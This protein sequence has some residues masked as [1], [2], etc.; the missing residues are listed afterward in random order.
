MKKYLLTSKIIFIVI[1][2]V[3]IIF[4]S[5]ISIPIN[6]SPSFAAEVW[7]GVSGTIS[8][9]T[10]TFSGGDG[11]ASTPYLISNPTDLAQFASNVNANLAAYN[12]AYYLVT[13]D[14]ELND[15]TF[16]FDQDTGLV[17]VTDGTNTAYLGTGRKGDNSGSNNTF[18]NSPSAPG[19]F[20]IDMNRTEGV[21]NGAINIWTPTGNS[22]I[23]FYGNFDGGGYSIKGLY[24][25]NDQTY[26]GFFGRIDSSANLAY[27]AVTSSYICAYY[28]IGGIVASNN[29]GR[30]DNCYFNGTICHYNPSVWQSGNDVGGIL[31][32]GG[33]IITNC[34]FSGNIIG[35]GAVGGI[36]GC[37]TSGSLINCYNEGNITGERN[38]GGII[39]RTT[40]TIYVYNNYSVGRMITQATNGIG[41]LIGHSGDYTYFSN[42]Y[43]L[44][45]SG[46]ANNSIEFNNEGEF[47]NPITVGDYTGN[48]LLR[49]LNAWVDMQ[50]IPSDYQSWV[51]YVYPQFLSNYVPT[52][53]G[54]LGTEEEPYLIAYEDQLIFL[55]NIINNGVDAAVTKGGS[56]V[57][58][59]VLQTA[60]YRL[61]KNIILNDEI[62]ILDADSGL[63][64]MTDG[65]NTAYLGT[66]KIGNNSGSNTTFDTTA[67]QKG[68]I[69]TDMVGTTGDY[70]GEINQW[71]QIGTQD[72]AFQGHFDGG[73]YTVS[74]LYINTSSGS[75]HGL[76]GLS[77]GEIANLGVENSYVKGNEYGGAVLAY[78][79]SGTVNNC[80]NTGAVILSN[81][82]ACYAG[83]IVG[84][85]DNSAEVKNC[86]NTGLVL[87]SLYIGGVVGA[88]KEGSN[89]YNSYNNGEVKGHSY[90][91]GVVG[92]NSLNSS[93]ENSYNTGAVA[94]SHNWVGGIL[95]TNSQSSSIS[96]CYNTGSVIGNVCVGGVVG[97][98]ADINSTVNDC[99]YLSGTAKNGNN[100]TQFGIG[101]INVTSFTTDILGSTT[102]F[103][104]SGE[105]ATPQTVGEYNGNNLLLALK[106][107]VEDNYPSDYTYWKFS[108]GQ[109][110]G[111]PVLDNQVD[112]TLTLLYNDNILLADANVDL[113]LGEVGYKAIF[114]GGVYNAT[115]G[116]GVYD[117][118]VN[119]VDTGID[120]MVTGENTI[121]LYALSY[122]IGEATGT[123]PET[124]Y[125]GQGIEVNVSTDTNYEL[126]GYSFNGFGLAQ[127]ATSAVTEV[128]FSDEGITLYALF[129]IV[130][131]IIDISD[132]ALPYTYGA[133]ISATASHVL[134]EESGAEFSYEWKV[135]ETV[136]GTSID[137]TPSANASP[138]EITCSVTFSLGGKNSTS[139]VSKSYTIN[140][141]QLIDTT[142]GIDIAY[143]RQNHF[144]SV[145]AEGFVGVDTMGL[146]SITYC[147][148]EN[149][150]YTA[151][152]ILF[153]D[154]VSNKTVYYRAVFANYEDI[155]G[156]AAV[157][158]AKLNVRVFAD[159]KEIIFGESDVALTYQAEGLL[160]GDTLSGELTR[161]EGANAGRYL[162]NQG[163]LNSNNY[164]IEYHGAIYSIKAVSIETTE[165]TDNN[166]AIAIISNENGIDPSAR[167]VI[168]IIKQEDLDTKIK[169]PKNRR[170]VIAY[171]VELYINDEAVPLDGA[172]TI[173]FALPNGFEDVE[174]CE[175]LFL[176]NGELITKEVSVVNGY[177][178]LELLTQGEFAIITDLETS[179]VPVIIVLSV[180]GFEI[181]TIIILLILR[182]KKKKETGVIAL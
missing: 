42:N 127:N 77:S 126:N 117:L 167:L 7:D 142:N 143:D 51:G 65:V 133:T 21:Y 70:L 166:E 58:Y 93:I 20:Y 46:P 26:M 56:S 171:Q 2:F 129:N 43:H 135:G 107:W 121:I 15:E 92:S 69:Y 17:I 55:S 155:V 163:S 73:N 31:G 161:E 164:N 178:T 37:K 63:I 100:I 151:D 8:D 116:F 144:I 76:F 12:A 54:G 123:A 104:G 79:A 109:N 61:T 148:T 90:I 177:I 75:M 71:T 40:T 81:S 59:L 3:L 162:I 23:S 82:E 94:A 180:L 41:A 99:Y 182:R 78:N 39:G 173:A 150:E 22:S 153:R 170:Y 157:T 36:V 34:S 145:R 137:Y 179:L 130:V 169:I 115:V 96:N 86:Y 91:G 140:K 124:Y 72:Y 62:F 25:N 68:A 32:I 154:A 122:D 48:T 28:T 176:E 49:A 24:I 105:L 103:S 160:E 165:K 181:I 14:I 101:H 146:A 66:G 45:G 85:N 84:I 120:I 174:E 95:G 128:T 131:P 147:E 149:G 83:G 136:V 38:S 16:T 125:Y 11:T 108:I 52:F 60:Y 1:I 159:D 67:S 33:G 168:R 102:G 64:T 141:K 88:N 118:Y 172:W 110:N 19:T 119:S 30:I 9:D 13:C 138:Y 50:A 111:Y 29:S 112:A 132:N 5:I 175:M 10:Y 4:L 18:D 6:N 158:I 139:V 27:I 113:Y 152:N 53:A 57:S 89:V 80:Y 44:A 114:I 74:G 156:S 134:E 97:V 106:A 98:N 35:N 47:S 87:G